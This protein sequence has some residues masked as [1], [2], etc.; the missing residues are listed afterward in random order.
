LFVA[1]IICSTPHGIAQIAKRLFFLGIVVNLLFA[2]LASIHFIE[3]NR[4]RVLLFGG[5][6]E[7]KLV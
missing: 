7:Q 6:N 4:N 1:S 3:R 5:K 2:F